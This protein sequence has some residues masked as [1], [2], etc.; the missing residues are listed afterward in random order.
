M[1]GRGEGACGGEGGSGKAGAGQLGQGRPTGAMC[2]GVDMSWD[3]HFG[4][5]HSVGG[6]EGAQGGRDSSK[7]RYG[8]RYVVA[9]RQRAEAIMRQAKE[10]LGDSAGWREVWAVCV[11]FDGRTAGGRQY[12]YHCLARESWLCAAGGPLPR[13][14]GH[15]HQCGNRG[16]RPE[17]VACHKK[18][19]LS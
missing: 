6:L 9:G 15:Q 3:V 1:V 18:G 19:G 13:R 14:V 5:K 17:A 12:S 7:R 11:P 4:E 8:E 16:K 2:Q 10:E